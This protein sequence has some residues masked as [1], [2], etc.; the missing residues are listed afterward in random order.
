MPISDQH[1]GAGD[2]NCEICGGVGYLSYDVEP[3]H[4]HFGKIFP[5]ECL[6]GNVNEARQAS[7]R[8]TGGLD[9]LADKTFESFEPDTGNTPEK[10]QNLLAAFEQAQAFATEPRGWLTLVGGFGCGKTHLAAAI[11]NQQIT[12]GKQ[13]IFVTAPD[14]LDHL[15]AAFRPGD[16]GETFEEIR[17]A[18]LLILDDLGTESPTA[19][20]VEKL[21]QILNYRYI[22]KLPTVI[23]TNIAPE[24]LEMRLRSRL[25]D[26]EFSK[27]V[28]ITA[29]DYRRGGVAANQSDLDTLG[30]YKEMTFETFELRKD[31][32]RDAQESLHK[33]VK[34]A[35]DYA[36]EPQGWMLI[37]GDYG[38]GK[39]HLAAAIANERSLRGEAVL[40]ITVPDLLDHLRSAYAPSSNVSYDKRFA[41]VK[42]AGLL[43]LDDLGTESATPWAR[44][45]LYQLFNHRYTAQLPTVITTSQSFDD[46]DRR[47]VTRLRDERLCRRFIIRAPAFGVTRG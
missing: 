8:H 18:D 41:E 40:F 43:V 7:L 9:H 3:E 25:Q 14:L 44:E 39:T 16:E 35:Y 32:P 34:S 19:W 38:S 5:C 4:A 28:E 22:A 17:T 15:R 29:L 31:I 42:S 45:K 12:Q 46:L 23:T 2:P 11:A 30:L 10:R 47:L 13:V 1:Y 24:Q 36:Q 20:A 26:F 27:V 21:Y 37:M 33:I 6:R